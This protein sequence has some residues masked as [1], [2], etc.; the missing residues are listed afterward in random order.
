MTYLI[1]ICLF[2]FWTYE[3]GSVLRKQPVPKVYPPKNIED[4]RDISGLLTFDKVAQ[5]IIGELLVQDLKV[6]LDPR[7]YANQKGVGIQH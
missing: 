3:Y 5:K 1:N 4:L 6:K 7:Q 2:W